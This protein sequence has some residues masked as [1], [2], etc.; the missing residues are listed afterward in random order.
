ML[1][2]ETVRKL[3]DLKL[4]GMII[5]FE[6]QLS[7]ASA[8]NLSFEERVSILVDQEIIHRENS[9][10]KTLLKRAK[11]RENACVEDIEYSIS[12]GIERKDIASLFL[13]YWVDNA[14]NLIITGPTGVGKTWIGCAFGNLLCRQGKSV[15]FVR[16]SAL[17]EE[18]NIA[19][20]TK[21]LTKK[22]IKYS[23]VDILIIDDFGLTDI[24]ADG[25]NSLLEVIEARTGKKSTI[26]TSQ[27]PVENWHDY[28]NK[29]K[30]PTIADA[31]LDRLVGNSHRIN[32][33][34]DSMRK[35]KSR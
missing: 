2:K 13:G 23:R 20:A 22:T 25:K 28:L 16:L 11:L 4:Y 5:E 8:S 17:L 21:S 15:L 34:G 32:L 10:M 6:G 24:D 7:N 1:I 12:R 27:L 18:L 14:T 19:K 30:S 29:G 3:H 9:R 26:I 33:K 35:L 31:I